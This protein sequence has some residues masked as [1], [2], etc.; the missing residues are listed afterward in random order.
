MGTSAQQT[1]VGSHPLLVN[2]RQCVLLLAFV[3]PLALADAEADPY[4]G[5]GYGYGAGYA[6]VGL[7][8]AG[9]AGAGV[10][11]AGVVGV[12]AAPAVA[13]APQCQTVVDQV[14]SQQC[15]TVSENVCTTSTVLLLLP[16][17]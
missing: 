16:L 5:A 1:T 3:A 17:L 14:T 2:M 13:V 7:A 15:N 11:G 8:G 12:A 4:Y 10:V 6:G 9:V